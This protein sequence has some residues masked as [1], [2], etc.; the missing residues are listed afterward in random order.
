MDQINIEYRT[1]IVT[2]TEDEERSFTPM[3]AY[4]NKIYL[5]N[6]YLFS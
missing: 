4:G 3:R 2:R 6:K 1:F 5:F